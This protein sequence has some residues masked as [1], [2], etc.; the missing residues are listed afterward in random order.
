MTY[1]ATVGERG[2]ITLPKPLRDRYGLRK[3][4]TVELELANGQVCL[5][6]KVDI[7]AALDEAD[8]ILGRLGKDIGDVDAFIEDIRGR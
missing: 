1:T 5:R 6:K 4:M 8:G 7:R 3:G 2:Q